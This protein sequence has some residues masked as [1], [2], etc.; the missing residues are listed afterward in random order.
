MAT[1]ADKLLERLGVVRKNGRG[2]QAKCPAHTDN[3]PSLSISVN[4][5]GAVLIKCF[6]S[7]TDGRSR[8]AA[9]TGFEDPTTPADARPRE[10]IEARTFVF[11]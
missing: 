3:E 2:W 10:S 5:S 9:H 8:F 7:A 1:A 6:D 11:F 4:D